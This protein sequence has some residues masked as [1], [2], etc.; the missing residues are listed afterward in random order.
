[1]SSARICIGPYSHFADTCGSETIFVVDRLCVHTAM[2][3]SATQIIGNKE[4][5]KVKF[6]Q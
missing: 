1:M 2:M 6:F 4:A 5:R 3:L